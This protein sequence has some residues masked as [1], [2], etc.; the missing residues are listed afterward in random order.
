MITPEKL[1]EFNKFIEEKLKDKNNYN[2][3][4]YSSINIDVGGACIEC[5]IVVHDASKTIEL[6]ME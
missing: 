4:S 2:I 5:Q 6:C 3:I 1:D